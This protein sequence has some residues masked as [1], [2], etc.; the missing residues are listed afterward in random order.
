MNYF[1]KLIIGIIVIGTALS[2]L[3]QFI[4]INA[5]LYYSADIFEKALGFGKEDI[6]VQQIL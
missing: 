6:L 3:Q 1:S 2:V 4:G 5:V